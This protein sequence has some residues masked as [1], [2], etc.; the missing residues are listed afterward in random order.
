[1]ASFTV[2]TT[3]ANWPDLS[4][5]ECLWNLKVGCW[6]RASQNTLNY[7]FVPWEV[8]LFTPQ[9]VSHKIKLMHLT[10]EMCDFFFCSGCQHWLYR[11]NCDLPPPE[12]PANH[13][14][15]LWWSSCMC[16][17][18]IMLPVRLCMGCIRVWSSLSARPTDLTFTRGSYNEFVI[19][20]LAQAPLR[21]A[22]CSGNSAVS[23][24]SVCMI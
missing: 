12:E 18:L 14:F 17:F 16:G 8:I 5:S 6:K 24:G 11:I 21:T 1:M 13:K 19:E 2:C 7:S 10:L 3:R 4:S 15:N 23:N 20:N 22:D 9:S